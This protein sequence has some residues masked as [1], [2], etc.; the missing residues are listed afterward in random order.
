MP[1]FTEFLNEGF[2]FTTAPGWSAFYALTGFHGV[3]V[4]LG[5]VMLLSCL[6]L[7]LLCACGSSDVVGM[8]IEL[9]ADGSAV[10]ISSHLL[11]LVEEI[12]TSLLLLQNGKKVLHGTI[13]EVRASIPDLQGGNLESI[14]LRATGYDQPEASS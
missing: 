7:S 2:G 11:G 6:A 3:H 8:H 5:I 1:A 9:A 12:A 4:T 14:F 10:I 13:A